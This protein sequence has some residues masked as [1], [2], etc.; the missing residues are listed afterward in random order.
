MLY[1]Q[2]GNEPG[3]LS[4]PLIQ[5]RKKKEIVSKFEG[6]KQERYYLWN[7]PN[8]RKNQAITLG[9]SSGRFLKIEQKQLKIKREKNEWKKT[10]KIW[11][12]IQMYKMSKK[13]NKDVITQGTTDG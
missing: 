10:V 12:F 2:S 3:V 1:K 4:N 9:V 6:T 5:V 13:V 8:L 11:S 7:S